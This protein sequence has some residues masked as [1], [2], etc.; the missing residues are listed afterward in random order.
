MTAKEE[1]PWKG[2]FTAATDQLVEEYTESV[3]FDQRL[4]EVDIQGS[5]AHASMLASVGVLT[6][7]ESDAILAGLD[8]ILEDIEKGD[9]TWSQMLE[10]VHMNIEARLTE[11]IGDVGKK[12]HTGRSRNDQVA[13]DI[14]LYLRRG[15]DGLS[16]EIQ[17]LIE[18]LL[19]L[20][21]R[22]YGTI[23]P[24]FTHLQVAQPITFGHHMMAW[25]EM[26]RR[27][28]DRLSDCRKRM[29]IMPLGAAALAGTT[30]PVDRHFT[31]ELLGFDA[32]AENSL[33]AVSDRDFAMEFISVASIIMIHLSRMSE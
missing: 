14:R 25:V 20:A 8:Q 24:G 18:S 17:I 11:R 2:R 7:A 33:D 15:I 10:D 28:L 30:F 13:T 4:Y 21:E 3:S 27:D 26:L 9:F 22:E 1:K 16:K 29:N 6:S 5:K 12:L 32:P 31:A 23:M 19:D